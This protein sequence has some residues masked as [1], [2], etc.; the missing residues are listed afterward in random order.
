MIMALMLIGFGISAAAQ[1]FG[2]GVNVGYGSEVSKPSF[3][4]KALYDINESF[5]VAPSF[6]YYLPKTLE[7]Y[8]YG[9]ANAESKLKCWDVNVDLH[10]T[11]YDADMYQLYPLVGVSYFNVKYD[12]E[13]S[14]G[15]VSAEASESEGKF[16]VNLGFGG[17]LYLTENWLVSA[18][19]KYQIISDFN[20][21]VPSLSLAYKF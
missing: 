3:G 18:E 12:A 16:G 11:C 6:N 2:L 15:G 21:F 13:A 10:W 1:N 17:Q 8:S 9:G 7:S 19:V 5:T 4:V 20:Q 14:Y